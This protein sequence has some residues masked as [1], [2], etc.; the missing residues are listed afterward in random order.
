MA[1]VLFGH[2]ANLLRT[3]VVRRK[4]KLQGYC[5]DMFVP[6]T[7]ELCPEIGT[8]GSESGVAPRSPVTLYWVPVLKSLFK[9]ILSITQGPT[10]WVPGLLGRYWSFGFHGEP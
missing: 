10:T 8:H 9:F 6:L 3:V 1:P 5:E 2:I 4:K 7:P